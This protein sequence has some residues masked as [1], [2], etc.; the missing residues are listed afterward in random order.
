MRVSHDHAQAAMAEELGHRSKR[1]T[2]HDQPRRE[3]VP[4]IDESFLIDG[5]IHRLSSRQL[6]FLFLLRSGYSLFTGNALEHQLDGSFLATWVDRHHIDGH[7]L[8]VCV[9][10]S[11]TPGVDL[12]I[13][14][15]N[16]VDR[17]IIDNGF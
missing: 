8:A 15:G 3:G 14:L 11:D 5:N 10:P 7:G 13:H 12:A 9:Y 2:L 6:G 16:D 1:G 4:Q 17:M